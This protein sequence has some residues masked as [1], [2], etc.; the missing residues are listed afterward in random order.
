MPLIHKCCSLD[1]FR[2]RNI[3]K[4]LDCFKTFE[5]VVVSVSVL[6]EFVCFSLK[7][8]ASV[9]RLHRPFYGVVGSNW[10]LKNLFFFHLVGSFR[11]TAICP[12]NSLL[13][14]Y[15]CN[16]Q[17]FYPNQTQWSLWVILSYRKL[18]NFSGIFLF[19]WAI[20]SIGVTITS[21]ETYIIFFRL[22]SVTW[23][24]ILWEKKLLVSRCLWQNWY[25][26]NWLMV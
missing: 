12:S 5:T 2:V 18:H 13:L 20:N 14:C 23:G 3:L 7:I 15:D 1:P 8:P 24:D 16:F 26:Y 6:V 4:G 25:H 21:E 17:T 9:Q 19:V 11:I 10:F 22:S